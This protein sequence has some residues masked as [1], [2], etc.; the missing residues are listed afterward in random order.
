MTPTTST[1]ART[2]AASPA[3]R[4]V[5]ELD[6]LRLRRLLERSGAA[7][8]AALAAALDHAHTVAAPRIAADVVTMHTRLRV[9]DPQR[10]QTH[11]YTL[12][13][14]ADADAAA[15]RISVLS[16]LGTALLGARRGERVAFARPD[17]GSSELQIVEILDQPESRGD[18][19]T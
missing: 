1:T 6:E 14:P 13:Y 8:S 10:Q 5:T 17:G 3:L 4:T 2:A 18:Y 7:R 11:E 9:L 16:P 15:A 12:C 19:T